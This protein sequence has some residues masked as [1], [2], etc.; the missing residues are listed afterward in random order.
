MSDYPVPSHA[1]YIWAAGDKIMV[2]FPPRS[3]DLHGHTV[4]YPAT[5]RGIRLVLRTLA[6]RSKRP[7][8]MLATRAEPTQDQMDQWLAALKRDHVE[9]TRRESAAEIERGLAELGL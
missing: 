5:E 7:E 4:T 9:R 2:G 6:E 8:A 1:A 3:G